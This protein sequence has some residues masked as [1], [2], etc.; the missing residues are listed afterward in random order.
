MGYITA[1]EILKLVTETSIENTLMGAME[2]KY[3]IFAPESMQEV[4]MSDSEDEADAEHLDYYQYKYMANDDLKN[5]NNHENHN[6]D[7]IVADDQDLVDTN[8]ASNKASVINIS[9]K[10]CTKKQIYLIMC[11]LTFAFHLIQN[12]Y[13]ILYNF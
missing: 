12:N 10:F 4:F 7:T 3:K 1:V 13:F 2:Q 11:F 8:A 5:I 9:G 6:D